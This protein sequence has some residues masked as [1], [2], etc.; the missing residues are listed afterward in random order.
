MSWCAATAVMLPAACVSHATFAPTRL[1][2]SMSAARSAARRREVTR[3]VYRLVEERKGRRANPLSRS[4]PEANHIRYPGDR[5]ERGRACVSGSPGPS[6]QL[7]HD[8][9]QR[10]GGGGVARGWSSGW[11]LSLIHI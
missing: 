6:A 8:R 5:C 9:L 7:P 4:E 1:R 2:C 10:I 3:E 11:Q